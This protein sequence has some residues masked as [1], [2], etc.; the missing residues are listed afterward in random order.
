LNRIR[1]ALTSAFHTNHPMYSLSGDKSTLVNI[2]I[3]RAV[4]PVN[5]GCLSSRITAAVYWYAGRPQSSSEWI[6]SL[7]SQ[8]CRCP[9]ARLTPHIRGIPEHA[10]ALHIA[11]IN[12]KDE[13]GSEGALGRDGHLS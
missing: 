12:A 5:D 9:E 3:E 7:R 8:I 1:N 10:D 2:E 4:A 13:V 6:G 11:W